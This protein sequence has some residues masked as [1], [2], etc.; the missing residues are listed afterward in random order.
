MEELLHSEG[1]SNPASTP[2]VE[3]AQ[4]TIHPDT[5]NQRVSFL[6]GN[7]G[8]FI[9]IAIVLIIAVVG[10]TTL[11]GMGSSKQYQGLIEKVRQETQT[12]QNSTN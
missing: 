9:A 1:T 3:P 2:A 11:M 5:G 12:L 7:K 8:L 4:I 6:S 10:M